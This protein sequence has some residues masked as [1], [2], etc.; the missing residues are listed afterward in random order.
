MQ[1]ERFQW[2]ETSRIVEMICQVWKLDRMF[3]SLKNGMIFSQEYFYDVL[4]HSTDLFIATKQQRIVGFLA[5]SLSKKD[6]ILIPK[7]YQNNL[8]HQHDDF[9][10]ISSYRQMMQNYHQNCE[11]LLPKMH[12]NYDGEI[13]LFMVDE[14]YQHQGL[15]TKL[16]EY[17]ECLFKKENCSHYILY[18]DTSCSYEFYDHHQMK[19]LDQYRRD[20]DFT[21]YLYAKELKSMEYRQLPHGYEKIS[22]IGLGTSSLGESSDEEIIATIQEAIDQGVNYL[23][24]ASGHAKTFQAIGQAIKGQREKVYLQIHFGANYE[25]GEYGWTT[26]LDKIKQSIQWQLEMLQTD[27][28]DFGLIHCI[29]EEA[30]IKAIEKAGV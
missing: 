20:D 11:Q 22:V 3:K 1:I 9:H 19:R 21:I 17:A 27:Y 23:D 12:Q 4:L 26:N 2:K 25:T 7:E 10:L 29:D 28:I 18:T 30:D 15:G 16:Y 6:K 8:Y 13:V 24:L 14:T 5:L